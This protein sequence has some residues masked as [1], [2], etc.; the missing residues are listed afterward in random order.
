MLVAQWANPALLQAACK[1][2]L[3]FALC[4]VDNN[5][6]VCRAR[7]ESHSGLQRVIAYSLAGMW[8]SLLQPLILQLPGFVECA[9]GPS[10]PQ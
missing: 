3:L 5:Y 8:N 10:Y 6:F 2:H 4:Q 1:L 7:A 9:D